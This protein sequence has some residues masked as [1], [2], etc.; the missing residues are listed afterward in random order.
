[1]LITPSLHPLT[2]HACSQASD[3][4]TQAHCSFDD[5]HHTFLAHAH[6]LL[7]T[8]QASD[9]MA[10]ARTLDFHAAET[11]AVTSE[12]GLVWWVGGL[13]VGVRVGEIE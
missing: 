8:M 6:T 7:L 5:A 13:E 12:D 10:Q 3:R 11:P 9:R 4:M 1:M 2:L